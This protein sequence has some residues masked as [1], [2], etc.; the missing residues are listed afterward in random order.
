ME[1]DE[2]EN[3]YR[4]EEIALVNSFY[5]STS[6]KKKYVH[7]WLGQEIKRLDLRFATQ[8]EDAVQ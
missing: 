3:F 4:W 2:F 6:K 5:C 7:T 8:R 1:D